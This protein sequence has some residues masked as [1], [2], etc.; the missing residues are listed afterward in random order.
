VQRPRRPLPGATVTVVGAGGR[1]LG[2][3]AAGDD[4]HFAV[5]VTA[6]GPATVI[7]TGNAEPPR[8]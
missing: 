5:P 3:A 1:Q 7:D 8:L 6:D 2:R 4:G